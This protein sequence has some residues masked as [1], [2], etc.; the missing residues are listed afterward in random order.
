MPEKKIG[1]RTYRAEKM[2]A[3]TATRNL[4]R[5][6]KI[7]GPGMT[8]L[9]KTIAAADDATRGHAA[10]AAIAD[11]LQSSTADELTAF[12]VEMAELAQVKENGG[13]YEGVIYDMHFANDL[14]EAFQV[15]AFVLQ[16][17]YRDFFGAKL[18]S[19]LKASQAA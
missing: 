9:A 6:T 11:I 14:L 3:T 7:V 5:L 19:V 4:I 16:V 12:L 15:V 1:T 17:N 18:G 8:D 13:S 2:P 10:L